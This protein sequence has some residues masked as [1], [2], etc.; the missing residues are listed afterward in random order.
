MFCEFKKNVF[1]KR[2]KGNMKQA[3]KPD[4]PP[5][6]GSAVACKVL[7]DSEDSAAQ[8]FSVGRAFA[9]S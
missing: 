5:E 7:E 4:E 3:L 6:E 1:S 8:T 2:Q 9:P